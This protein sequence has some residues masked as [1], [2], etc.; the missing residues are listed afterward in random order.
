MGV[1]ECGES[2]GPTVMAG[3]RVERGD[4]PLDRNI[5]RRESGQTSARSFMAKERGKPSNGGKQMT[6]DVPTA[7]ATR[8]N[9][10][11]LPRSEADWVTIR[12]E[13]RRLQVRIVKATQETLGS[14][15][16]KGAF[17]RA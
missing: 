12:Q 14:R 10:G 9:A 4:T 11:A 5:M 15:V 16:P 7:S 13:V 3:I 6:A 1:E 17:V 2:E 8:T